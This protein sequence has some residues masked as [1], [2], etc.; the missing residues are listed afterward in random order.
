[1]GLLKQSILAIIL[2]A[3]ASFTCAAQTADQAT[4][5]EHSQTIRTVMQ[6]AGKQMQTDPRESLAML[7]KV[8]EADLPA[9]D[10]DGDDPNTVIASYDLCRNMAYLYR[11]AAKAADYCGQ[12][13]KAAE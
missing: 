1:M 11:E 13:E 5:R 2:I 8:I 3:G 4:I 9:L 10:F 7:E 6:D 12:W